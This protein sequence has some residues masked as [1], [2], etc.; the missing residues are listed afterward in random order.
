MGLTTWQKGRVLKG[1]VFTAKNYL[2]ETE[3]A[4]LDRLVSAFLDLAEDR[5][6]RRQQTTMAEWM[7]FV[8]SYLKLADRE[9]LTHAGRISHEKMEEII[10]RRYA[11]FDA[12]RRESERLT[13]EAEH[14]REIDAELENVTKQLEAAQPTRKQRR[15]KEGA[16]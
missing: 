14:L 2:E 12:G 1:D 3:A 16:E 9:I 13:A 6:S 7:S 10:G 15:N 4:Q 8:D 5:A 11:V